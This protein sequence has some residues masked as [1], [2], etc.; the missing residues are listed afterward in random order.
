VWNCNIVAMARVVSRRFACASASSTRRRRTG[1]P[2]QA[3]RASRR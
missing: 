2:S 1:M 3:T